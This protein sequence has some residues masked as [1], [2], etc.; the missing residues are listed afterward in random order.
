[1]SKNE[2][3][4]RAAIAALRSIT[5]PTDDEAAYLMQTHLEAVEIELARITRAR[6]SGGNR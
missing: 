6:T 4:I 1:M 3:H 2:Q 5:D